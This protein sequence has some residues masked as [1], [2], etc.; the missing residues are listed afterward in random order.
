VDFKFEELTLANAAVREE[1][2]RGDRLDKRAILLAPTVEV[3]RRAL[4]YLLDGEPAK[5]QGL[6]T[7]LMEAL[8]N[9]DRSRTWKGSA[10][11]SAG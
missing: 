1:M 5:A 10:P 2:G 6:L 7:G 4:V 3:A 9:E 11:S 8:G